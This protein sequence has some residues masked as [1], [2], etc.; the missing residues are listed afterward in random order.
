MA[1][2]EALAMLDELPAGTKVKLT[3]ADGSEVEGAIAE[4]ANEITLE[5]REGTI[6]RADLESVSVSF[7]RGG[8]E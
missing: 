4:S 7:S 1:K 5:D 8:P 2:T 6:A 3:L